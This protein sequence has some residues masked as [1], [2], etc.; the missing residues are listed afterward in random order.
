MAFESLTL[1]FIV[2][3]I[4]FSGLVHGTLGLGFPMMATPL[5]ALF[6]DVQTAILVTLFPTVAVNIGSI[7]YGGH[8][9]ESIGRYWPLAF[10]TIFGSILGSHFLIASDPSPFRL[11]LA[12]II[13]IYLN[14][15]R[16]GQLP[17]GWIKKYPLASMALFGVVGGFLAGSVNVMV[18]ILVIFALELG[19]K[20]TAMIQV[21][22]LCFLAG[23]L[24]QIGVFYSFGFLDMTTVMDSIPVIIVAILALFIGIVMRRHIQAKLYKKILKRLLLVVSCVLIAEYFLLAD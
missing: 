11:L 23:K 9:K 19:L 4:A 7:I 16:L 24:S 14:V 13:L 20:T 22:N 2:S 15:E 5:L 10:F 21:F 3:V 17:M 12:G 6:F 1:L 18:P 8:W